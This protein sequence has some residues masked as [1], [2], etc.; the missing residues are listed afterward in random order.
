MSAV[1]RIERT[2][3]FVASEQGSTAS[4]AYVTAEHVHDFAE[5][6]ALLCQPV[7]RLR[8]QSFADGTVFSLARQLRLR[9]FRGLI[10]LQGDL[11]P[12]QLPLAIKAGVDVIEISEAHSRRCTE[13]QW[14]S[15]AHRLDKA[16][17]QPQFESH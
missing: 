11:L 12:D 16:H 1:V 8:A 2:G 9:G 13:P 3:R 15:Q 5:L 7:V 17:Y 6:D 10:E 14:I 4:T